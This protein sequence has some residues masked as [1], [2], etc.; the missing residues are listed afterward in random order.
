MTLSTSEGGRTRGGATCRRR[1]HGDVLH[2]VGSCGVGA[3]SWWELL[4]S[5]P[6]QP[7]TSEE[8]RGQSNLGT[9]L[10]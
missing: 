9:L 4:F 6:Y 1:R 3:G 2:Q 10:T 5:S 7:G 8:V